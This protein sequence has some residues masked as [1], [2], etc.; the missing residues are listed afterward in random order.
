MDVF[1]YKLNLGSPLLLAYKMRG[2]RSA[3]CGLGLCFKGMLSK[4]VIIPK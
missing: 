4:N 1:Q 3:C 2:T